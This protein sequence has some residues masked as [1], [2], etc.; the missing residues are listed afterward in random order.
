MLKYLR[1]HD[2]LSLVDNSAPWLLINLFCQF[3]IFHLLSIWCKFRRTTLLKLPASLEN[4]NKLTISKKLG[5]E[6]L[7]K[8][9]H[10]SLGCENPK[11][12]CTGLTVLEYGLYDGDPVTK[13]LLQPLT[14]YN[15]FTFVWLEFLCC[16]P[17]VTGVTFCSWQKCPSLFSDSSFQDEPI[18]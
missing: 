1:L 17:C 18:N 11:P 9:K 13:V 4:N 7:V 2:Y 16:W 12:C 8:Y 14:G 5:S 10:L 15:S 6:I 3:N